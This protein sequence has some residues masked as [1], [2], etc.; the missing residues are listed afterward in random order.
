MVEEV[1]KKTLGKSESEARKE[2]Q[3]K[4]VML[5][6]GDNKDEQINKDKKGCCNN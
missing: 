2:E 3:S 1:T 5:D 4:G 6:T